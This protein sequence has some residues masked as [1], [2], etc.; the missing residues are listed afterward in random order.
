MKIT[1]NRFTYHIN[2]F[3]RIHFQVVQ[4]LIVIFILSLKF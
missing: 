3:I 1:T 4:L 2:F